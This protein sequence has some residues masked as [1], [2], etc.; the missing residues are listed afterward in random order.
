VKRAKWVAVLALTGAIGCGIRISR[1][2]NTMKPQEVIYDDVCKVQDYFDAVATGQEKAPAIVSS[3]D[4]SKGAAEAAVGGQVTFSFQ[5]DSQLRLL[6]RVLNDNWEKLPEK[7]AIQLNDTH[8]SM[9]VAELMRILKPAARAPASSAPSASAVSRSTRC[10]P[11][12][13]G[14][15]ASSSRSN[16]LVGAPAQTGRQRAGSTQARPPEAAD[17]AAVDGERAD[18]AGEAS[19]PSAISTCARARAIVSKSQ[20]LYPCTEPQTV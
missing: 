7:A 16:V 17:A 15:A 3:N 14:L 13:L 20:G 9:A 2:L 8:P 10:L 11:R 12:A 18:G 1:D 19:S 5:S 4:F 6:R